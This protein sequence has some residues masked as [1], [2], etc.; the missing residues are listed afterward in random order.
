MRHDLA[1]KLLQR[2]ETEIPNPAYVDKVF[3][4]VHE[5]NRAIRYINGQ[6]PGPVLENMKELNPAKY[7]GIRKEVEDRL[8]REMGMS[9][10]MQHQRWIYAK[11]LDGWTYGPKEDSE[12]KMH[13]SM[14][15]FRDL[16]AEER[17]KDVVFVAVIDFFRMVR[18][19]KAA[20]L[21]QGQTPVPEA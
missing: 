17:L 10:E 5:I 13:P 12:K 18:Q 15:S 20:V 14:R 21:V 2:D 8:Y 7:A 19:E 6:D 16:P 9:A 11:L 4:Y 3:A 1:S